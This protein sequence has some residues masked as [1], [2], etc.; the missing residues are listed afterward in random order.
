MRSA[1]RLRQKDLADKLH[2]TSQDISQIEHGMFLPN[3]HHRDMLKALFPDL[4]K[5]VQLDTDGLSVPVLLATLDSVMAERDTIKTTLDQVH[6]LLAA[7][8]TTVP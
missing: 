5:P 3:Q 6:S 2:I 1:A 4:E 7:R 8:L